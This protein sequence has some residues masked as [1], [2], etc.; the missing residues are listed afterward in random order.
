[1]A[2]YEFNSAINRGYD[3]Q[4]VLNQLER[5]VSEQAAPLYDS[6]YG[7]KVV[8]S[9]ITSSS[10]QDPPKLYFQ[11]RAL[12]EGEAF[13]HLLLDLKLTPYLTELEFIRKI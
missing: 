10:Q 5:L 2:I 3:A 7:C 1:M 6:D 11:V 12:N 4:Y 8:D 9:G 13:L